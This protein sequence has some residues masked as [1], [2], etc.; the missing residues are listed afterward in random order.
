MEHYVTYLTGGATP[1]FLGVC[2]LIGFLLPF[3][4][5][6]FRVHPSVALIAMAVGI[7]VF[8]SAS[9]TIETLA[10]FIGMAV[11]EH[12]Q[13]QEYHELRTTTRLAGQFVVGVRRHLQQYGRDGTPVFLAI[14]I[15]VAGVLYG[16]LG[17]ST[18]LLLLMGIQLP[19]AWWL[20]AH[21]EDERFD[22]RDGFSSAAGLLSEVVN[23][24]RVVEQPLH[25]AWAE[26]HRVML[27]ASIVFVWVLSHIT[28]VGLPQVVIW[29]ELLSVTWVAA[30]NC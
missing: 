30:R 6:Q 25:D 8:S 17:H 21:L 29:A 11:G 7:T 16:V 2:V 28:G 22:M 12:F 9:Q 15:A 5:P 20:G 27:I 3:I 4:C 18:P 1:E 13:K 26:R 14:G 19:A 24:L 23:V 10:A